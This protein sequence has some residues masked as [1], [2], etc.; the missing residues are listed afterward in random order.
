MINHNPFKIEYKRQ[1]D[2]KLPD[3]NKT[4]HYYIASQ[5]DIEVRDS[6]A[7]IIIISD[8]EDKYT[9]HIIH[10]RSSN[11]KFIRIS[12]SVN[13]QRFTKFVRFGSELAHYLDP[14]RHQFLW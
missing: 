2:M 5:F 3:D 13:D 11:N 10:E 9:V 12:F 7:N 8:N 14:F 6:V 1:I 4:F